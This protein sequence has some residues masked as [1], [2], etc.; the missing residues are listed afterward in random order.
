MVRN[1]KL[2]GQKGLS[3][4]VYCKPILLYTEWLQWLWGGRSQVKEIIFTWKSSGDIS[5]RLQFAGWEK[6]FET[7]F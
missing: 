4:N 7:E 1:F 5:K 2:L 6:I 3:N